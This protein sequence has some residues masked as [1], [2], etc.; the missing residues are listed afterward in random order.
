[1]KRTFSCLVILLL[2][3]VL[4]DGHTVEM[5][6]GPAKAPKPV[7]KYLLL[8]KAEEQTDVDAMPLYEK[9]AQLLPEDSQM[10]QISQWLKT[11]PSKFPLQQVQSTLQQFR[12]ILQL[13]EQAAKCKQCDWPYTD[14]DTISQNLRKYRRLVFFL[15]LQMH[16]QV[17]RG[18]FDRAIGTVQTGFAMA[19][20]IGEGPSLIHG[21]IGI[22]IGGFMCGQ[23]EQFVQ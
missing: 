13:L 6:L 4:A 23:L 19:K 3:V 22:G 8:P 20:H 17:A 14:D 2:A 21:L 18:E 7:Q 1:M 10:D 16:F 11:S 5:K 9:A 15:A 12:P